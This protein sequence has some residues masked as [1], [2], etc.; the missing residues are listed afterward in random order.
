M[1]I[2]VQLLRP[3]DLVSLTI[4]GHNLR[5]DTTDPSAPSLVREDPA[6]DA[7]LV[8]V[9]PPQSFAE[10]ALMEVDPPGVS[11]FASGS[12]NYQARLSGPTRVAFRI[13]PGHT[14]PF[15]IEGL[16]DWAKLEPSLTPVG[17][18]VGQPGFLRVPTIVEP[19]MTQTAIELPYRLFISP[20]PEAHWRHSK[21]PSPHEGCTPLWSTR[22]MA[23]AADGNVSE[24]NANRSTQLRAVY[25]PD[26]DPDN[27]PPLSKKSEFLMALKPY[28][29]HALVRLTSGFR[30]LSLGRGRDIGKPAETRKLLLTALGG[31]LDA[32]GQ[33]PDGPPS[34][35][36]ASWTHI[37]ALGRDA[38]VRATY[39]GRLFPLMNRATMV[40]I[41][42]RRFEPSA[43]DNGSP[44]AYLRQ[45][46]RILVDE[47]EVAYDGQPFI[48]DGREM[49]IGRIRVNVDATPKIENP[50]SLLSSVGFIPGTEGSFEIKLGPGFWPFP[51]TAIDR[52][53]NLSGFSMG[54]IFVPEDD[55]PAKLPAVANYY[56][57]LPKDATVATANNAKV[58]LADFGS[59]SETTV[60]VAAS[61]QFDVDIGRGPAGFLPKLAAIGVRVPSLELLTGSPKPTLIQFTKSY[62]DNGLDPTAGL[63]AE[64]AAGATLPVQ[65]SADQA[66]GIV[67][68]DLSVRGFSKNFGPIAG[69]LAKIPTGTFDPATA[70][71][72]LDAKLFGALP[73]KE[74]LG[75]NALAEASPQIT[76]APDPA[77]PG[78]IVTRLHWQTRTK[79]AGVA[80]VRFR[81][82]AA[83]VLT[84]DTEMRKR[85]AGGTPGARDESSIVGKLNDFTVE[86]MEVVLMQFAEFR[87]A[88]GT[89]TSTEVEV[90]LGDDDP[91]QFKGAL[92]FVRKLTEII[93]PGIFGQSG[94]R[95]VLRPDAIEV[96]FN[97]PLPPAALGIFSIRN[98]A[99]STSLVLPFLT[100]RPSLAFA[101]ATREK[102]FQVAVLILGGGGFVR[103]ELDTE[104][105]RCVEVMVEF[106]GVVAL[107]VGVAS[108]A[109]QI[110][111]G[112]Y[113]GIKG[114]AS[115]LTGY[116]RVGGEVTVL[117]VVSI[118]IE[119][120]LSL[121][122]LPGP[123]TARGVARVTVSVR[124]AFISTSVSFSVERSFSAGSKHLSIAEAMTSG[125]WAAYAGAF[126]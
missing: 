61:F 9:F 66:G 4:E 95:I 51:C 6:R 75:T 126:A 83:T 77:V 57:A 37:A 67:R 58:K 20:G 38:Y 79:D 97:L 109:V 23:V 59:A 120:M 10:Q 8:A 49:P 113:I 121:S 48:H 102:P 123:K 31:F 69:D 82:G 43:I 56:R 71:G 106:G 99:I 18:V 84:I 1:A 11:E 63:F 100:G 119:F 30:P 118:S 40:K 36:F 80:A 14:I 29:R 46:I 89:G 32:G 85:V 116:V 47:K 53:G 72:S 50:D 54:L 2:I 117:A 92:E 39:R 112:I 90:K 27:P 55:I 68:P 108:G 62:L 16:L 42:E 114:E 45:Y 22:L 35:S 91:I 12:G 74:I 60:F 34:F 125:D 93:P 81:P 110:M 17:A 13:P 104:R 111:A 26:Y 24:L 94:P 122:Y 33:W 107:D 28:D 87:F 41:T 115:E 52:A 64:I 98:I 7:F 5:L 76:T 105:I 78:V 21:R 65:F 15:S 25:S 19:S 86:L 124:I 44:V 73:I 103:I 88:S 70:F 96:G 101:F 3:D